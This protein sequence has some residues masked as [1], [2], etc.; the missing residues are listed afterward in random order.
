[1]RSYQVTT[2]S[3]I[4]IA[5]RSAVDFHTPKSAIAM[6]PMPTQTTALTVRR[7]NFES[8]SQRSCDRPTAASAVHHQREIVVRIRLRTSAAF[9][10]P[11]AEEALGAEDEDQ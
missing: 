11:L 6:R 7:V 5:T 10:R 1:M 8:P 9:R 2:R 4:T 3:R